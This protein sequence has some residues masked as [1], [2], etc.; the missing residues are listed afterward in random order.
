MGAGDPNVVF[1]P[2]LKASYR[3]SA[4]IIGQDEAD[5]LARG[6]VKS[7]GVRVPVDDVYEQR[8]SVIG[9]MNGRP[10]LLNVFLKAAYAEGKQ[11]RRWMDV[12]AIE[13]DEQRV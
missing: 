5:R 8:H 13:I 6:E 1:H 10:V 4:R 7:F 3:E 12:V 2:D 11:T 9:R